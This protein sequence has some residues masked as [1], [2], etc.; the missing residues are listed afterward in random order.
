VRQ[1]KSAPFDYAGLALGAVASW[2]GVPGPGEPLLVAAGLLAAKNKLDLGTVLLV[3]WAA[4]TAGGVAGWLIGLK[5]GRRV[6]TG[7]GPLKAMRLRALE[8]G[9]RVFE[10]YAAIAILLTPSWVAGINHVRPAVYL[11]LNAAGAA[12]WAGG[13]GIGAYF[14]G[15]TVLD[16]L[17]DL[18]RVAGIAVGVAVAAAVGGEIVRRRRRRRASPQS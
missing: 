5:A 6:L 3:A 14:I 16:I 9:E 10:R 8:H 12:L 4:A 1:L 2:I 7:R 11:P 15:P 13:I 18:G 17:G